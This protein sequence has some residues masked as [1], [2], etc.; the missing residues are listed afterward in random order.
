MRRC[1]YAREP[2]E[3]TSACVVL[4]LALVVAFIENLVCAEK[5]SLWVELPEETIEPESCMI[6]AGDSD[7]EELVSLVL[8]RASDAYG[9]YRVGLTQA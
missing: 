2:R 5:C 1:L 3:E 8:K 6:V 7:G 9:G 4:V